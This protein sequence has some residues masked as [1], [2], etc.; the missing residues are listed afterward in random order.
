MNHNEHLDEYVLSPEYETD[1]ALFRLYQA[2]VGMLLSNS[3][4][5]LNLVHPGGSP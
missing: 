2:K 5:S 3:V 1:M 4:R